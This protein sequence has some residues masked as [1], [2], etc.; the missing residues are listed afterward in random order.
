MVLGSHGCVTILHTVHS[1]SLTVR[2][3]SSGWQATC[4]ASAFSCFS[5]TTASASP[6]SVV[7]CSRC[8]DGDSLLEIGPKSSLVTTAILLPVGRHYLT[9]NYFARLVL[10]FPTKIVHR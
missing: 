2:P 9:L 10:H 8:R 1:K 6:S 3:A 4:S 5:F 7:T